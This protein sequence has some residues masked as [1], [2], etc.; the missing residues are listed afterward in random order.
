[1]ILDLFNPS[2]EKRLTRDNLGQ[3]IDENIE[4]SMPDGRSVTRRSRIV[5]RDHFSQVSQSELIYYVTHPDG[6][7]ERFVHAFPMRYIFRFEAEH[8]LARLPVSRSRPSM[9]TMI[10]ARSASPIPAN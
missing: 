6:R 2:L 3:E 7:K 4:F 5:G 9:P 8:L 1:M 10:R